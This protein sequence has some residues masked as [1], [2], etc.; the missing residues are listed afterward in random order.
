VFDPS[1]Y[2]V[3]PLQVDAG[4]GVLFHPCLFHKSGPN[5]G[6]GARTAWS[7]TWAAPWVRY[8][9]ERVPQHAKGAETGE[10]GVF[11]WIHTVNGCSSSNSSSWKG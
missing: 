9:P 3:V 7:S 5:T 1:R 8:A 6:Q 11:N 2:Q 4:D 10:L